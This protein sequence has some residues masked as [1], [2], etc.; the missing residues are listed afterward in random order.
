[1]IGQIDLVETMCLRKTEPQTSE[2]NL[3]KEMNRK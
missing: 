3:L 1:M 2:S